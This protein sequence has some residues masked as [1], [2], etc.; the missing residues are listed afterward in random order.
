MATNTTAVAKQVQ[1]DDRITGVAAQRA[2]K[3]ALGAVLLVTLP[4]G[5][6]A[7]L[8]DL[9]EVMKDKDGICQFSL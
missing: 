7:G 5:L 4:A 6:Q 9:R 2:G 3:P 8:F 1:R